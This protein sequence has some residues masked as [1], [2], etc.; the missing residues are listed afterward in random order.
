[1]KPR[2]PDPRPESA[3]LRQYADFQSIDN[4]LGRRPEKCKKI[5]IFG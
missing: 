1:M 2:V 4:D 3:F 5:N